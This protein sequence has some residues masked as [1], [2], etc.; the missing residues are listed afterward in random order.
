MGIR[1]ALIVLSFKKQKGKGSKMKNKANKNT[2]NYDYVTVK[3]GKETIVIWKDM[4]KMMMSNGLPPMGC[5]VLKD[6]E[7]K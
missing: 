7:K 1:E 2:G 6:K 3:S 4:G 5:R